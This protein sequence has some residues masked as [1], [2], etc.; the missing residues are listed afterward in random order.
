MPCT[1]ID[2]LPP[3]P[4]GRTGW[5]WVRVPETKTFPRPPQGWPLITIV[6]PSYNQG[7]FLEETVR[8]VLLQGYPNL[9]YIIYDGGSGDDSI[10]VL[11]HYRPFLSL[12]RSESDNGQ[13]HA[14]NKGFSVASGSV[15]GWLNSDDL[16]MP[17]ALH[18]VAATWAATGADFLYGDGLILEQR[19]GRLEYKA[20]DLVRDRYLRFGGIVLQPATFWSRRAA[21]PIWEEL[22]CAVDAELWQ[23]MVPGR[24]RRHIPFPLAIAR[25]HDD[26]KT[27]S[28][29]WK[30]AWRRDYEDLIRPTYPKF[31][32]R[33]WR[34]RRWEYRIVQRFS[35]YWRSRPAP[36][37][38][39]NVLARP[40][41]ELS[42]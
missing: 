22:S 28:E 14:I 17:G 6:T 26:A 41:W 34:R 19:S 5:P 15:L 21:A 18:R 9:E 4:D 30:E 23:R 7:R 16:L 39:V 35:R 40:D 25:E 33:G 1:S 29:D 32:P 27:Q 31:T 11:E 36:E 10:D 8:S 38:I 24:T 12:C 13:G 37:E 3:P 20:V 42:A 2:R